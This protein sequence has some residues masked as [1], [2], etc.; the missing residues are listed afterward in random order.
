[1]WRSRFAVG[2]LVLF[3]L[4][5]CVLRA[6]AGFF[7]CVV[8]LRLAT[9][10]D[11]HRHNPACLLGVHCVLFSFWVTFLYLF[12]GYSL[13]FLRVW[14]GGHGVEGRHR[15]SMKVESPP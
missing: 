11:P 10:A 6:C 5:C 13:S 3:E 14:L 9:A 15:M 1:M 8:G 4:H 2:G 12:R 7:G